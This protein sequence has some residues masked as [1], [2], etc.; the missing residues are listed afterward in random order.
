MGEVDHWDRST[1]WSF[2]WR[3]C[4]VAAVYVFIGPPLVFVMGFGGFVLGILALS[5]AYQRVFGA[6]RKQALIIGGV[7][8][9]IASTIFLTVL[10]FVVAPLLRLFE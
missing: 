2:Y 4:I 5:F 8:G 3:Y 9:F 10:E 1:F 6:G 7:G